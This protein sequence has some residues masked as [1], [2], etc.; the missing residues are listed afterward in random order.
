MS[1]KLRHEYGTVGADERITM[2]FVTYE[3]PRR[4]R[5]TNQAGTPPIVTIGNGRYAL[6]NPAAFAALGGPARITLHWEPDAQVI[7]MQ[8]ATSDERN[9]YCVHIHGQTARVFIGGFAERYG[10][11]L[12]ER[13]DYG[14]SMVENMLVVWCGKGSASLAQV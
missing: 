14:A 9:A 2:N 5:L 6:L 11:N 3:Q 10:I 12:A 1:V 13:H 8:A 7:G 4:Q